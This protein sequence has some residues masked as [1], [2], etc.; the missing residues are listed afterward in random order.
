MA[1]LL[2]VEREELR[3]ELGVGPAQQAFA[4]LVDVAPFDNDSGGR[5]IQGGRHTVREVLY[6][7]TLGAKRLAGKKSRSHRG[8]L[9]AQAAHYP[10][11]RRTQQRT[12]DRKPQ[13]TI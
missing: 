1:Q 9:H 4:S 13:S 2:R 3:Q 11:R 12:L 8:R 6:M 10:Q 5:N 7:A